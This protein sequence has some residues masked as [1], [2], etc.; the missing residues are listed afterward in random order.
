MDIVSFLRLHRA[1]ARGVT[2][3]A[4]RH[5]ELLVRCLAPLHNMTFATPTLAQ[6]AAPKVY[7]HRIQICRPEEE[8]SMMWGSNKEAVEGWLRGATSETVVDDVLDMVKAPV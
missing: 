1:T 2:P 3:L 6:L 8:R 4:T 5:F 7:A